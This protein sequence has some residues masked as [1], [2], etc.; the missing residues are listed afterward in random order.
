MWKRWNFPKITILRNSLRMLIICFLSEPLGLPEVSLGV[1]M[2]QVRGRNQPITD[3]LLGTPRLMIGRYCA[4]PLYTPRSATYLQVFLSYHVDSLSRS[5]ITF[6]SHKA[7]E[8]LTL[9]RLWRSASS[10]S[11]SSWIRA[12][13]SLICRCSLATSDCSSSI[14]DVSEWISVSFLKNVMNS[15]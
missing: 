3:L 9:L 7:E 6:A 14:R 10:S 4:V 1:Y 11:S 2:R 12:C 15:W 5:A 8:E 13:C